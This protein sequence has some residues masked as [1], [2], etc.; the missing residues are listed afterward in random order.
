VIEK[1]LSAYKDVGEGEETCKI[2][3]FLAFIADYA[4]FMSS[5]ESEPLLR[6]GI[7]LVNII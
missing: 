5:H 3:S 6:K 4:F 2:I 1:V 7:V